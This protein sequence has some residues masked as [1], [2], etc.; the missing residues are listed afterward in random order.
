MTQWVES[1]ITTDERGYRTCD[2]EIEAYV[3]RRQIGYPKEFD[4]ATFATYQ[5]NTPARGRL[6]R[7][8]SDW[9]SD[10]HAG[11][12]RKFNLFLV[13][14]TGGGKTHLGVACLKKVVNVMEPRF[15]DYRKMVEDCKMSSWAFNPVDYYTEIPF[16][17]IDEFASVE[18]EKTPASRI[19]TILSLRINEKL[20]TI[21][22]SNLPWP[23]EYIPSKVKSRVVNL[24]LDERI[25]SRIEWC[26]RIIQEADVTDWRREGGS[27]GLPY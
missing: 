14:P 13:A 20:P 3:R 16:L 4:R 19:A 1:H 10:W 9:L 5:D 27:D 23:A 11:K 17:M 12:G 2:F 21:L 6:K 8:V 22:T 15:F 26:Y 24:P 18:T 25:Q 7:A